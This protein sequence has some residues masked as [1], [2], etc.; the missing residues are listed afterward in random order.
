LRVH[1]GPH[2]QPS[3]AD[4]TSTFLPF[5]TS[6]TLASVLVSQKNY[7]SISYLLQLRIVF[8]PLPFL[9]SATSICHHQR[10]H[11]QQQHL[12][13]LSPASSV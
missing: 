13:L 10:V 7:Q 12:L 6:T 9:A 5:T 8:S 11:H 3:S 2:Q 1:A 4:S